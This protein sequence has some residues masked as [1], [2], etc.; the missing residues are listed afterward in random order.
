MLS[1]NSTEAVLAAYTVPAILFNAVKTGR[2]PSDQFAS[3]KLD[4]PPAADH[5]VVAKLLSVINVYSADSRKSNLS[6]SFEQGV[7]SSPNPDGPPGA[8]T[9]HINP[10]P[11][12]TLL[13]MVERIGAQNR[14]KPTRDDM[15]EAVLAFFEHLF[16]GMP[17]PCPIVRT[18]KFFAHTTF[19]DGFRGDTIPLVFRPVGNGFEMFNPKDVVTAITNKSA[20]DGEAVA[21]TSRAPSSASISTP[22]RGAPSPGGG[23]DESGPPAKRARAD[24]ATP[25]PSSTASSS[26]VAVRHP[27]TGGGGGSMSR[28]ALLQAAALAKELYQRVGPAVPLS[29]GAVS[30]ALMAAGDAADLLMDVLVAVLRDPAGPSADIVDL[31]VRLAIGLAR[32][33]GGPGELAQVLSGVDPERVGL[34]LE[35]MDVLARS[36]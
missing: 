34:F 18:D 21:P 36:D 13:R 14:T 5:P 12:G 27:P 24:A 2:I 9:V 30:A 6:T 22:G 1:A 33:L 20:G 3:Y 4:G 17:G 25:L 35:D 11:Q 28:S 31:R 23:E 26:Y 8:I 16:S 32:R 10:S 7:Y 15:R 29:R 19:A